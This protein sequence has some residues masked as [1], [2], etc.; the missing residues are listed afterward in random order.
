MRYIDTFIQV[1]SD[2]PV[3]RSVIPVAKGEKKPLHLIQYELLTA[4]PYAYNHEELTF[5]V[6]VCHKA[7]PAAEVAAR[8]DELW[9]E[10]FQKGH[11]CMRASMLTKRYGWGAHYN[12]EGKIAL[13]PM[14]SP[15][16]QH[17]VENDTETKV[18]FAM[19]NKRG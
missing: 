11:P 8:R 7:I 17:F 19:R 5:A 10:L 3:T 1:A 6:Y 2:C 18:L 12:A 4:Q 15:E 9:A 16:Y 13:Y 14:E